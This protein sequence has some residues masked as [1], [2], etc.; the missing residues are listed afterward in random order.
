M[1]K[2]S[3]SGFINSSSFKICGFKLSF[4]E[5]FFI[6]KDLSI[7]LGIIIVKI[8]L[9]FFLI[10]L[11][12]FRITSS[13]PSC[14][15]AAHHVLNLPRI[16]L[17]KSLISSKLF[18]VEYFKFPIYFKFLTSSF[19]KLFLEFSLDAK[20]K[21]KLLKTFLAKFIIIFHLLNVLFVILPLIN[22]K[23]MLFFLI[24]NKKFGQISESTKQ[25][26]SGFHKSKKSSES[27]LVS[28]GK[29]LCVTLV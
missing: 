26:K 15:L 19:S 29:N 8:L 27:F 9:Y 28:K 7:C 23:G 1:I 3:V 2:I 22:I 10:S 24:L 17:L 18:L 14:V 16:I 12:A 25:T 4:F 13:S 5:I 6:L 11:C 20:H 21:S